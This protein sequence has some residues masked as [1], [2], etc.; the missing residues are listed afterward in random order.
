MEGWWVVVLKGERVGMAVVELRGQMR[1][2]EKVEGRM[3]MELVEGWVVS[4]TGSN[5]LVV[6]PWIAKAVTLLQK[7]IK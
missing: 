7:R 6:L 1:L 3:L 4:L 2:M 5:R